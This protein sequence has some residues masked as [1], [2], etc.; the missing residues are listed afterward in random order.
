MPH[1]SIEVLRA[2]RQDK[3]EYIITYQGQPVARLIPLQV[4]LE[5]D[6]WTRLERLRRE[7]TANWKSDK[8]AAEVV[9]EI[10]R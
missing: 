2:V 10:R 6:I 8:S 3:A 5:E 4:D 1:S 9:S 7:I